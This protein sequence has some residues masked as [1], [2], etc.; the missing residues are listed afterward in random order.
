MTEDEGRLK[1]DARSRANGGTLG[2]Q[3]RRAEQPMTRSST[4]RDVVAGVGPPPWFGRLD[5][6]GTG[7]ALLR[8]PGSYDVVTQRAAEVDEE[9]GMCRGAV[10]RLG[11][12]V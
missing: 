3:R 9:R 8:V 10:S 12:K 4:T 11:V 6:P 7:R 2:A 1:V 5:G